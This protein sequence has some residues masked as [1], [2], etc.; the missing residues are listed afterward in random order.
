MSGSRQREA[1]RDAISWAMSYEI[2]AIPSSVLDGVRQ[3]GRDVS[4]HP[5]E[6]VEAEGGEPLRCCLRYARAGERII[7]FGHEPPLGVASPYREI[8]AVFAHEHACEGA[9][10]R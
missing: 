5:I 4:G 2:K 3:T 10:V 1:A 8:G 6:R 7:L 9:A